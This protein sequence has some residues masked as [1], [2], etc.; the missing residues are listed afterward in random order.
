M[1]E[2][3]VVRTLMRFSLYA[4]CSLGVQRELL[5]LSLVSNG[6]TPSDQELYDA[7][8]SFLSR[9]FEFRYFD[10]FSWSIINYFLSLSKKFEN[11][12]AV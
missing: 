9:R 12:C 3:C 10:R 4:I 7:T 8:R 11:G 6:L 1:L 2:A 5:A